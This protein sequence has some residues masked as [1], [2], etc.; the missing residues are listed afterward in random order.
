ME[1]AF[2]P[3]INAIVE[4]V[5]RQRETAPA[6]ISVSLASDPQLGDDNT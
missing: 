6:E 5:K 3:S 1:G 4:A 2:A